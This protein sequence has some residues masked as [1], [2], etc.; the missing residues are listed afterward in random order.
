MID[1]EPGGLCPTSSYFDTAD[2]LTKY[3]TSKRV[4]YRG[5][6]KKMHGT[7]TSSR[8]VVVAG[9]VSALLLITTL[10]LSTS[11]KVVR[12]QT[13]LRLSRQQIQRDSHVDLYRLG[14]Y[15]V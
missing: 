15:K 10:L 14:R 3:D 12:I 5:L 9:N 13:I 8:L 7:L 1:M 11:R 2:R 4:F 6:S